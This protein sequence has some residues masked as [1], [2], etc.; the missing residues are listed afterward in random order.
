MGQ[1]IFKYAET[2]N[3]FDMIDEKNAISQAGKPTKKSDNEVLKIISDVIAKIQAK[4]LK[5]EVKN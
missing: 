5:K 3:G 2:F 4:S 1:E